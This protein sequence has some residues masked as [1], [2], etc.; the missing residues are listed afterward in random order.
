MDGCRTGPHAG[1]N[2]DQAG[3]L[4]LDCC[5]NQGKSNDPQDPAIPSY[6]ARRSM[7]QSWMRIQQD[8]WIISNYN[9]KKE[10]NDVLWT[11]Q[12]AI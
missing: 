9:T 4:H 1:Q 12:L 5:E 8:V 11:V 6:K 10:L 3:K 2:P 7:V